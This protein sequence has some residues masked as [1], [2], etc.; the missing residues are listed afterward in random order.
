L[1]KNI[2]IVNFFIVAIVIASLVLVSVN[3]ADY[4]SKTKH[5]AQRWAVIVDSHGDVIA[6]ETTDQVVWDTLKALGLNQTE[7]WVGGVVEE[8]NNYWGFRFKPAS[9]VVAEITIEG[10]QSNIR[11]ISRDLDYWINVWSTQAYVLA[12]IS[13]LH[14]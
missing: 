3:N 8:Y 9:I 1:R 14:E 7:M 10:A 5:E 2:V 4:H 13:E 6:V 11:G 12:R